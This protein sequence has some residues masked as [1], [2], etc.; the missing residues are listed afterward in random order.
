MVNA[1]QPLL[2]NLIGPCNPVKCL[3]RLYGVINPCWG[4][5]EKQQQSAEHQNQDIC[6]AGSRHQHSQKV[7]GEKFILS[8]KLYELHDIYAGQCPISVKIFQQQEATKQQYEENDTEQV[9]IAINK[10]SHTRTITT[11]QPGHQE[12]TQTPTDQ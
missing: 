11:Q 9:E 8:Y 3:S 1:G 12:K 4:T 6:R 5:G 7:K 2:V 10:L